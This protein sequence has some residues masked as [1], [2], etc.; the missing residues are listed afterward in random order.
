LWLDSII[1][2]KKV[3]AEEE[4]FEEKADCFVMEDCLD[5]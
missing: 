3:E 2:S 1:A 4:E 5:E